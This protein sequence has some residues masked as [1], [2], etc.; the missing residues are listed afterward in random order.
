M[1]AVL[2]ARV[3]KAMQDEALQLRE[4]RQVAIQRGWQVTHELVDHIT[5][6]REK[7]PGLDQLI[8]LTQRGEVDVVAVWRLDRLAR[9]S[10]H[11]L[12]LGEIFETRGVHLVSVRDG[13]I[14]TTTPAGRLLFAVLG[15]MAAFERELIRERS[16]AGQAVARERGRH[17]GRPF[18]DG[19]SQERAAALIVEHGSLAAA[20]RAANMSR[21]TLRRRSQ[22]RCPKTP[23]EG[24]PKIQLHPR[25]KKVV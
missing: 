20:A 18:A 7:R 19:V 24:A 6:V 16:M 17:P 4:L 11:L 2:Y 12:E 25:P 5:A 14:D 22:G 15:A 8:T 3:S 9:S 1:R 23:S 10:R 13:T 21:T